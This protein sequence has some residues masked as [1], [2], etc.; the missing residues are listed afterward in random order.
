MARLVNLANS[1]T[2]RP[3]FQ[4]LHPSSRRDPFRAEERVQKSILSDVRLTSEL[5]AD[6][7]VVRRRAI[8][9]VCAPGIDP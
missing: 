1:P 8:Y 2:F 4:L 5:L 9:A 6:N 7:R 3:R